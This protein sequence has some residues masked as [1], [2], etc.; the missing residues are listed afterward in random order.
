ASALERSLS[1]EGKDG[2]PLPNVLPAENEPGP[3]AETTAPARNLLAT[4]TPAER[5]WS[6]ASG[7]TP[8]P[9]KGARVSW[10]KLFLGCG[11]VAMLLGVTLSAGLILLAKNALPDLGE[12]FKNLMAEQHQWEEVARF[13]RPPPADAPPGLLLPAQ[14]ADF[15]LVE[16]DTKANVPDLNLQ[17]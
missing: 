11:L 14:V 5:T 2:D 9:A 3:V 13:W 4:D 10:L 7:P 6:R 8:H 1:K 15:R 12:W 17:A 16:Q